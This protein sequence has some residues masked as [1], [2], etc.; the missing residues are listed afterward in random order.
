LRF[1]KKW[2]NVIPKEILEDGKPFNLKN[3]IK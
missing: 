1:L 2:E 3:D